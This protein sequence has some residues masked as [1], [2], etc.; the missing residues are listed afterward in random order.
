MSSI[1]RTLRLHYWRRVLVQSY[2]VVT[3]DGRGGCFA[4]M[5]AK[6]GQC[7]HH[8]AR[9]C[10]S[11]LSLSHSLA[12]PFSLPLTT[13][14]HFGSSHTQWPPSLWGTGFVTASMKSSSN[15][16]RFWI[17]KRAAT[18]FCPPSRLARSLWAPSPSPSTPARPG[19]GG[20]GSEYRGWGRI[21][22]TLINA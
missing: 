18:S 6:A 3:R 13:R 14:H 7:C 8:I 5:N 1:R 10:H 2:M 19:S 20:G 21:C 4:H 11:G 17:W 22:L 16:W 12:V 9:R 15:R